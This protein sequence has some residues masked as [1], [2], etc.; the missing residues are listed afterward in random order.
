MDYKEMSVEQ[1]ER[2][3]FEL[4]KRDNFAAAKLVKCYRDFYNKPVKVVKGRKVPVGTTGICFWIGTYC[5]SPYGDSWGIYTSY[6]VG[7]KD[8]DGKIYWTSANNIEAI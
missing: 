3:E 8:N 2:L 4:V 6:R 7:I 5:N 1:L